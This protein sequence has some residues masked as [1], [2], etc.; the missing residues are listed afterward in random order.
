MQHQNCNKSATGF[1][2]LISCLAPALF[3]GLSILLP[4]HLTGHSPVCGGTLFTATPDTGSCISPTHDIP[5]GGDPYI[6]Y[7]GSFQCPLEYDT[8]GGRYVGA[9]R[10]SVDALRSSVVTAP[11]LWDGKSLRKELQFDLDGWHVECR[12][13]Q[14][15]DASYLAY[16]HKMAAW[17]MLA[18]PGDHFEVNHFTLPDGQQAVIDL[19]ITDEAPPTPDDIPPGFLWGKTVWRMAAQYGA[20]SSKECLQ[21]LHSL[22]GYVQNAAA[23]RYGHLAVHTGPSEQSAADLY[24]YP[25]QADSAAAFNQRLH[26]LEAVVKPGA[27]LVFEEM[28]GRD[29]QKTGVLNIVDERDGRWHAMGKVFTLVWGSLRQL[30]GPAPQTH[31]GRQQGRSPVILELTNNDFTPADILAL[32]GQAPQMKEGNKEIPVRS[33]QVRYEEMAMSFTYSVASGFPEYFKSLLKQNL[34]PGDHVTLS[35][36]EGQGANFAD[37]RLTLIAQGG[38]GPK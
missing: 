14:A 34:K 9:V 22:P 2:A 16:Y 29:V 18:Q 19:H 25:A 38:E 7:W 28:T 35:F 5:K 26:N 1:S 13:S 37:L 27:R 32:L 30:L 4:F 17:A 23:N 21:L 20:I 8:A 15:A 10:I 33:M 11:F 6:F 36:I 24:Y 12:G 3:T 31:W